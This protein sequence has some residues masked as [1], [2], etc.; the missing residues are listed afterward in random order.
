M[1]A[2][3]IGLPLRL[4]EDD[5]VLSAARRR[6]VVCACAAVLAAA[7]ASVLAPPASPQ[8]RANAAAAVR[9]NLWVDTRG[10]GCMRAARAAPYAPGRAC[11]SFDAAYQ[12]ARPGDLVLVR[13]GDYGDVRIRS[14][15]GAGAPNVVLRTAPGARVTFTTLEAGD[16]DRNT[17][18]GSYWTVA[19]PMRGTHLGLQLLSH[20]TVS[21]VTL[22]GQ[23]TPANVTYLSAVHDVVLR[24]MNICCNLDQKLILMDS[25]RG[26]TTNVT[27]DHSYLHD[28][29]ASRDDVH[30]EC[31]YANGVNGLTISRS[32]FFG[33][34]GTG[35]LL[36]T[37]SGDAPPPTNTLLENNVWGP[38]SNASGDTVAYSIQSAPMANVIVRNNLFLTPMVLNPSGGTFELIGNI[39]VLGHNCPDGV[40]FSH[41]VWSDSKC[42]ASDRQAGILSSRYYVDSAHGNWHYAAGNPAIGAGDPG[43]H[44]RTDLD[45]RPRGRSADAGPYE[46]R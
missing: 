6:N 43:N 14:K 41:N 44:P 17:S 31:I 27:V 21:G 22:D 35:D 36:I 13:T 46:R 25:Y 11:G 37:Q 42:S 29:V 45:G 4:T 12:A 9:A 33:C 32:R 16:V 40:T 23:K 7:I 18:G 24:N 28:Q 38:G 2:G 30:M 39:G 5:H 26:A 10:G 19:G 3:G 20:V 15:A 34:K 1:P 8:G